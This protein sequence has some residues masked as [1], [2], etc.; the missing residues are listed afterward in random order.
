VEK[1]RDPGN[2]EN[3][4][5]DEIAAAAATPPPYPRR[6]YKWWKCVL[7]TPVSLPPLPCHSL[8]PGC[9]S[10]LSSRRFFPSRFF[11]SPS[12]VLALRREARRFRVPARWRASIFALR[13]PDARKFPPTNRKSRDNPSLRDGSTRREI[14]GNCVNSTR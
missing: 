1:A 2:G 11:L 13:F 7:A 10:A 5:I 8:A 9:F 4:N 12:F 6:V 3:R 14:A